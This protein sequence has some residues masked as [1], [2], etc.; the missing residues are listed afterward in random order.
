MRDLHHNL[1]FEQLLKAAAVSSETTSAA[2]DTVGF[3]GV[4]MT[5][6]VGAMS[7]TGGSEKWEFHLEHSDQAAADFEA[8]TEPSDVVAGNSAAIVGKP[9]TTTGVFLTVDDAAEDDAV[10]RIGYVGP[11]RYVRV[12]ATPSNSPGST[13][14]AVVAVTDPLLKPTAG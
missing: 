3:A 2:F 14:M 13:P 5:I 1:T 11:K 7:N 6:I 8:V 10:Y 4:D 9:D 12:V